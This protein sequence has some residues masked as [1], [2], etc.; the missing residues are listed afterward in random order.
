MP[1]KVDVY[2]AHEPHQIVKKKHRPLSFN[3]KAHF[4]QKHIQHDLANYDIFANNDILA[5]NKKVP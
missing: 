5:N 3:S 1:V 4:P 2:Q